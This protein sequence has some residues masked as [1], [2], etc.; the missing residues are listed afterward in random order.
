MGPTWVSAKQV[1]VCTP[2][3]SSDHGMRSQ[4]LRKALFSEEQAPG[5]FP[6]GTR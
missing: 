3:T 1:A 6:L 4:E 5:G 2:L